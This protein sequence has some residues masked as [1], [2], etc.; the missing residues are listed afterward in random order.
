MFRAVPARKKTTLGWGG[1]R[2]GAGRKPLFHEST[3]RTVRFERSDLE[4]LAQLAIDRR[5]TTADLVRE[6][7]ADYLARHR[8]K[9]RTRG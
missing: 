8:R 6:A 1:R 2:P 3:N 4:A 5:V 7:V 9:H